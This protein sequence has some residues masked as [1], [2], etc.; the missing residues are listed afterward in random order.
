[1]GFS[2]LVFAA[3]VYF[4]Y[5]NLY[6]S[7]LFLTGLSVLR[8]FAVVHPIRNRSLVLVWRARVSCLRSGFL[9]P[10]CQCHSSWQVLHCGH[11]K[12]RCFEPGTIKSWNRIYSLN[13]VGVS[14][15]FIIPFIIILVCYGCIICKLIKGRKIGNRRGNTRRRAVYLIAVVLSTFLLC[16]LPYHVARTVHLY[17]KVLNESCPVIEFLVK[18]LVISLC[19]AASNSCFNPL[20]YYF[21]GETFRTAIRRVSDRRTLGSFSN[22][23]VNQSFSTSKQLA[24]VKAPRLHFCT[25]RL[26]ALLLPGHKRKETWWV[27]VWQAMQTVWLWR[28]AS[29]WWW[30]AGVK[31]SCIW[32][33]GRN[34]CIE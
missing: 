14:L 15:G 27:Q 19:M 12:I 13:Y 18:V 10:S 20:L 32:W 6:T 2:R 31:D 24:E 5:V 17:A 11:N 23:G 21:A 3:G 30:F 1:M 8:Y 26:S 7:V 33:R 22:S 28:K 9:W 29:P 4:L 34:L 25:P 16:F